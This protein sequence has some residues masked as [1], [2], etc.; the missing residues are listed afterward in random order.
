[1]TTVSTAPVVTEENSDWPCMV[2]TGHFDPGLG[3]L[4]RDCDP[5]WIGRVASEDWVSRRYLYLVG[6]ET[7]DREV[8]FRQFGKGSDVVVMVDFGEPKT[9]FPKAY[10]EVVEMLRQ[11]GREV[12]ASKVVGMLRNV[13]EE[14]EQSNVRVVC[15]RDMAGV[16]V[17]KKSF[18]DPSIGC[19]RFG[20]VHAQWRFDG[21]G[22]VVLSFL[23]YGEVLLVA[24][25]G[26]VGNEQALDVCERGQVE[27]VLKENGKLVPVRE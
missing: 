24:Q 4:V 17:E 2:V 22:V 9:E 19:D 11:G 12:L 14:P 13:L 25:A 3:G 26:A 7:V 10:Q 16:M 15:L 21:D 1:M 8:K 6:A 23:G 20:V 5:G 27:C 18:A